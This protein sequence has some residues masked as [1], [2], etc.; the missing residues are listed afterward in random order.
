VIEFSPLTAK[1]RMQIKEE[2]TR[3]E[4]DRRDMLKFLQKT[5]PSVDSKD[6]EDKMNIALKQV[7]GLE[8]YR[9]NQHDIIKTALIDKRDV[10]V[11]MP[12]GAGKS[13]CYQLPGVVASGVTIVISPL[14]ALMHDQVTS[15][16]AKNVKTNFWNST[17]KVTQIR[18]ITADLE[19]GSP[20]LKLLYTTPE[21]IVSPKFQELLKILAGRQQLSL[22]AIDEAHCISSWGHDF[23]V[24]E[25]LLGF[26]TI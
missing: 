16:L 23:R 5:T 26:V 10:F 3:R 20:A 15:L 17:Q 8:T 19:S 7:F 6:M 18:A 2:L 13:L 22:F 25:L 4:D 9:P 11:L 21:S 1:I 24:S 14:I 12:T